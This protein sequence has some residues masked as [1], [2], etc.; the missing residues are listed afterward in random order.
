M[1]FPAAYVDVLPVSTFTPAAAVNEAMSR[2]E[3]ERVWTWGISTWWEAEGEEGNA[4]ASPRC[5]VPSLDAAP[6]ASTAGSSQA[7]AFMIYL[8]LLV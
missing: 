8:V 6:A 7:N 4:V 2:V 3:Q 1:Q 5:G